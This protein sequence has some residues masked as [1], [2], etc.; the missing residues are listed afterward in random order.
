MII[1]LQAVSKSQYLMGSL[2]KVLV[3]SVTLCDSSKY[4]PQRYFPFDEFGHVA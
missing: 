4:Q 1:L 3:F 2:R